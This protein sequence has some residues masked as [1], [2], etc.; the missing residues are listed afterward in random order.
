MLY[1][2]GTQD[3]FLVVLEVVL[4]I[5]IAEILNRLKANFKISAAFFMM[6]KELHDNE[7]KCDFKNKLAYCDVT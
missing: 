3:I 4:K 7:N 2:Y 6:E 1:F 5:V